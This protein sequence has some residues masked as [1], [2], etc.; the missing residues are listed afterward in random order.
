[1]K[2][3]TTE[4]HAERRQTRMHCKLMQCIWTSI[5]SGSPVV[6]APELQRAKVAKAAE[7]SPRREGRA[8]RETRKGQVGLTVNAGT[9]R[10]RDTKKAECR[11]MKSDIAAGKCD[12]S[13]KPKRVSIRSQ[14]QARRSIH[15]K[16]ATHQAWTAPSHCSR[17]VPLPTETRFINIIVLA[18]R[19]LMVASLDGAEYAFLDS[20]S[21]L[22]SCPI[23][24][25]DDLPLRPRLAIL[26]TLSNATGG[27]VEC[28]GQ[29][30]VGCRL[31]NGEPI[32]A[33]WHV[34]NV[35]NLT[36]STESL[37]LANIEVRHTKNE[38]SLILDR[39]GTRT[40]VILHK[41]AK[42]FWLKRRDNNI[43][44]SDLRIAAVNMKPRVIEEIDS[45]EERQPRLRR[46][47]E[48]LGMEDALEVHR[49]HGSEG[50]AAQGSRDPTRQSVEA[51]I[52][53]R[54]APDLVLWSDE[55]GGLLE[56][57]QEE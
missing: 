10:R 47:K 9:V 50:S 15:R 40:S 54:T 20:G 22:T 41:F 56:P 36:I 45:D 44:D 52:A 16:R 42:V 17:M 55:S 57:A 11:K 12:K 5:R 25:A 39:C 7:A 34:A 35:T 33:T 3:S 24:F 26:L 2:S 14:R 21:G 31:E 13:G 8:R 18:I 30:Q 38:S 51:S 37:T 27:G 49:T 32:V 6:A 4:E 28:I 23:N 43:L 1:M 53:Q 29:R 48:T 19:T 46:K